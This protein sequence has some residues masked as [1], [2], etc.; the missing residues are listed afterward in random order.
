MKAI[1]FDMDGTLLDSQRAWYD[2]EVSYLED[3]G[4]DAR[5][6]DYELLLTSGSQGVVEYL[7]DHLQLEL[8]AAQMRSNALERMEQFYATTVE[9][10]EGVREML[11][12]LQQLGIPMAV[13]SATPGE[14]CELAL[15]TTRLRPYFDFVLSSS[16]NNIDKSN[17]KFFAIA[18]ERFGVSTD[19]M[20]LFD[21]ALLALRAAGELG[22]HTV[23]IADDGYPQ[24]EDALRMTVDEFYYSFADLRTKEWA[25][26][27]GL[28]HALEDEQ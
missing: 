16:D 14:L 2:A 7:N 18:A 19:E 8:D 13:G 22:C 26:E 28:N 11:Q 12:V 15:D 10:K 25:D 5:D 20:V 9:P 23:G 24:D 1:L 6:V 4:V 3:Q 21:D 27:L 17:A